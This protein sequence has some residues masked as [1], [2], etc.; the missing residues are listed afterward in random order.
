MAFGGELLNGFY[1]LS[2]DVNKTRD[3]KVQEQEQGAVSEPLEE[4]RL[5][6]D[7]E[8]LLALK[9]KWESAW[10][11]YEK[12]ILQLQSENEKYWVGQ[13]HPG[14]QYRPT[15]R[16]L[17]DN[18]IFESLETFLPLATK[19]NPEPNVQGDGTDEG[20][21]QAKIAEKY[22]AFLSEKL[23][24]KEAIKTVARYWATYLLGV[25]KIGWSYQENE[26]SLTIPRPQRLILDPDATINYRMEYEGKYIGEV[27][28]DTGD[29]LLERFAK[30]KVK[31]A[32]E[33]E[34][35]EEGLE[36]DEVYEGDV[37]TAIFE[38]CKGKFGT[39]IQYQ[40]W[41]T[42]KYVFWTLKKT[43]L[44]K[45]KN[46]HWNYQG[47]P[48]VTTNEM[49]QQ[50]S[51]P[52]AP[53]NYFKQPK[54][55]YIFLS[56]FNIGKHPHDDTTLVTQN[57]S[58]QDTINKR[59][60]QIDKN[61]D[62]MNGGWAVSGE[63]SGLTR[64]E[65]TNAVDAAR[66]GG[67]M[68]IPQGDVN[69]AIVRLTGTGLPSD[70][71]QN[72]NDMRQE[73][74]NSFGTAGTAPQSVKSEDT[75]GGKI[76]LKTADGD[77]MSGVSTRLETFAEQF[78][79]WCMQM[80]Y[81]YYTDVHKAT[82]IGDAMVQESIQLDSSSYV[83]KDGKSHPFTAE[84]RVMVKD[85]SLI[86]KDPLTE[87]N[88]AVD[89]ASKGMLDPLTLFQKL[90]F[91]NPKESAE[92]FMLYKA[93]PAAYAQK[94]FPD[95]AQLFQPVAPPEKPPSESISFADISPEAQ[96][97]M[98]AKV[99]IQVTPEQQAIH[100]VASEALKHPKEEK[101]E[102]GQVNFMDKGQPKPTK[103]KQNATRQS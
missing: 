99:G 10:E 26:I 85:G 62:W 50:Q 20:T 29:Y 61:V 73:I 13:Q 32:E 36:N 89:L 57:L 18:L 21:D 1:S 39:E 58:K 30:K 8:E 17:T 9:K 72:L 51:I 22:L 14:L 59:Q 27:R 90:D 93:N 40:E 87:A 24:V 3:G 54:M 28:K 41:W 95:I 55:P 5:D 60:R 56:V 15:E 38:E 12:D 63:R 76:L 31:P 78:Y 34:P 83:G 69:A 11:P 66:K 53:K 47:K 81:V 74:R 65:A 94:Y 45:N 7:D 37:Y 64:D 42:P 25:G 75:M 4:L 44:G 82:V 23:V 92:R 102:Q 96:A 46:P 19:N 6:M 100:Q 52:T 79:N 35:V 2:D 103:P 33:G 70:I 49:G 80:I 86:P 91:S 48:Q 43:V 98:L 67:G 68:W 101:S 97:Q 84:L 71:F 16:P 88:Q 77:R